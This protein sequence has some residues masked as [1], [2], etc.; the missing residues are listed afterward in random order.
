MRLIK[1]HSVEIVPGDHFVMDGYLRF[2]FGQ[3]E[4]YLREGCDRISQMIA[5]LR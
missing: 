3:P 1:E 4:N 5:T 2:S